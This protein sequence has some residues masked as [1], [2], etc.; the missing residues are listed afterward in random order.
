MG[1]KASGPPTEPNKQISHKWLAI[2]GAS[3][4]YVVWL[5]S[6]RDSAF[7]TR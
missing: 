6:V 5:P 7:V 3:V 2:F 1:G 4:D